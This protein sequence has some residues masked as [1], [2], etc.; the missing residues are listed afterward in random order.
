MGL[1]ESEREAVKAD[2][3][4]ALRMALVMGEGIAESLRWCWYRDPMFSVALFTETVRARFSRDCDVRELTRF[5]AR[6]RP[7]GSPDA[8][9]FP[10]REAE[11]LMRGVLGEAEFFDAVHPGKFSYPEIGITVLGGLF[12]EWRPCP[13]EVDDLIVRVETTVRAGQELSPGLGP[14]E[15]AWF[16]AGMHES[17]FVRWSGEQDGVTPER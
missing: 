5:I 9:G 13:Q 8:A 17:P 4:A 7:A 15:E 10:A 16:A 12:G 14:A 2:A 6:H 3:R 11:A 1:L